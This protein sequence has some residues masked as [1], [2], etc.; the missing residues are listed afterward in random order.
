MPTT[1]GDGNHTTAPHEVSRR[2]RLSPPTSLHAIESAH[3]AV[4]ELREAGHV[5]REQLYG[6]NTTRVNQSELWVSL[7]RVRRSPSDVV[8]TRFE[9]M[10]GRKLSHSAGEVRAAEGFE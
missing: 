10:A 4:V 3:V 5:H 8:R 7:W 2:L 6:A 1:P 9:S